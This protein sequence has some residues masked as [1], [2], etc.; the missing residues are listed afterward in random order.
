MAGISILISTNLNGNL[1]RGELLPLVELSEVREIT[2]VQ[3]DAGPAMPKVRYVALGAKRLGKLLHVVQRVIVLCAQMARTRP[4]VVMGVYMTP[5]GVL[6]YL[7]ARLTR[8]RLCIHVIGGPGEVM[9][10]GY[11]VNQ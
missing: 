5:H 3:D 1:M 7:L 2:V 9:D 10:G 11:W 4:S 8:R 6:A